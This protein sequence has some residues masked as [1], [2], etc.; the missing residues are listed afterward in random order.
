M[1]NP[2]LTKLCV[3]L[4]LSF[5]MPI[6][7]TSPANAY[8]TFACMETKRVG[9]DTSNNLATANFYEKKYL[10]KIDFNKPSMIADDLGLTENDVCSK[11]KS[12]FSCINP[13]GESFTIDQNTKDFAVSY[14]ATGQD[15][16][17][18]ARGSCV[19][20]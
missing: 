2:R 11:W 16:P 19:K 13:W 17:F 10:V 20:F 7:A 4:L 14:N 9:L 15:D 12:D 5:L 18:V 3:F 8:T 6:M 1:C